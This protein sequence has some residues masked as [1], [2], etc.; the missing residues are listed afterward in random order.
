MGFFDF[1][2]PKSVKSSDPKQSEKSSEITLEIG[3]VILLHWINTSLVEAFPAYFEY[4]Y[5]INPQKHRNM[6]I[7][8]GMLSYQKSHASL[9][10]LKVTQ[11]KEILRKHDL[12]VSGKK[13]ILIQRIMD[14]FNALEND[15]PQS[16]CL[17]EAG[18]KVIDENHLLIRA[19]QDQF[20]DVAKFGKLLHY[21]PNSTYEQLKEA[22]LRE[23]IATHLREMNFGLVRNAHHGLAE[24]Y[25]GMEQYP[26]ALRHYLEVILL[27]CSGLGNSY[28][29]IKKPIYEDCS[30]NSY[31]VTKMRNCAEECDLDEYNMAF[32]KA[33][34]DIK[35]FKKK[36]FLSDK[37][38]KFIQENLL[39]EDLHVIENYL[40]KFEKFTFE[41]QL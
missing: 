34:E 25:D 23:D 12:P 7:N 28:N 3:D 1:L 39:T 22:L 32:K 16:L 2:K 13:D 19:H 35:S 26:K 5:K 11:L 21:N 18:Q 30:I 10:K 37:D 41:Y 33:M 20:V 8:L 14:N 6:L 4:D 9:Q 38:F 15:I 27:D 29:F 24:M 17:T 36:M 31:Q 40:R